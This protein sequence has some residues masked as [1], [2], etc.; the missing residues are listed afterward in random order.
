MGKSGPV[1]QDDR[2]DKIADK[3][4]RTA[5][6]AADKTARNTEHTERSA[7]K[8]AHDQKRL[9]KGIRLT[10]AQK[11]QIKAIEKKSDASYR[12]LRQKEK[13]DDK[14]AKTNGTAETDAAF[15][16]QVSQLKAQERA[17]MRAVLT[18]QQQSVFDQN[19]TKLSARK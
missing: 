9:T 6:R 2:A 17:E 4:A 8:L 18:A 10:P 7:L 13:A 12:D 3:A 16:A 15:M 14:A 11:K 19:V 5:D 1:R